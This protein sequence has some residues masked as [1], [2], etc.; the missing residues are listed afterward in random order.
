MRLDI[1]RILLAPTHIN[2]VFLN[3]P[4]YECEE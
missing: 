1:D 4:Q 3:T 2:K